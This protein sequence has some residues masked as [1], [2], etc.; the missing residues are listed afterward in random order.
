MLE[1]TRPPEMGYLFQKEVREIKYYRFSAIVP[2]VSK[3]LKQNNYRLGLLKIGHRS[4]D[5]AY[6]NRHPIKHDSV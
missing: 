3:T 5:A 6:D 1:Q 2:C 4:T